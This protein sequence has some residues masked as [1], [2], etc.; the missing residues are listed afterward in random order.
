MNQGT[1]MCRF[2]MLTL[3]IKCALQKKL[4]I[5]THTHTHTQPAFS[6][7]LL[8]LDPASKVLSSYLNHLFPCNRC[9]GRVWPPATWENMHCG[10]ACR[11]LSGLITSLSS[12]FPPFRL[13][14]LPFLSI[15]W[16]QERR[17]CCELKK[18]VSTTGQ[19]FSVGGIV[20]DLHHLQDQRGRGT[21]C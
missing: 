19:W 15:A 2:W 20:M 11:W 13:S 6:L 3:R 12:F 4:Y 10:D 18:P 8:F 14:S 17:M 7:H 9:S 16:Y 1:K 5:H 21:V